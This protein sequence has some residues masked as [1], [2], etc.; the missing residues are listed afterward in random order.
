M[1]RHHLDTASG[2][3]LVGG[4]M[5]E[6]SDL[7]TGVVAGAAGPLV[8]AVL[9]GERAAERVLLVGARAATLLDRVPDRLA[10][11]VLVRGLP[12]ARELAGTSRL[13]SGLRVFTGSVE[14]LEP[15][16]HY[17]VLVCLDGPDGV[18][19]P[20]SDGITPAALL[21]LLGSWLAPGGLL[22]AAVQNEL[23]L[24]RLLR[25]DPSA[26][27]QDDA[28]HA[29]SPGT[30]TRLPYEREVVGLL[31]AAGLS[32]EASWSGFP[33]AD[34]L[35]LLV[36]PTRVGSAG[37]VVA[38]LAARLQAGYF[39]DRPA[40]ADPHDLALRTFEGG[41][42]PAL[43]SAWVV[44]ARAGRPGARAADLPPLLA[45]GEPGTQPWRA[46]TTLVEDPAGWQL[47]LA[48]EAGQPVVHERHVLRDLT[49]RPDPPAEGTT[50][51]EALRVA[52]RSGS[53]P[54][55]RE[56]VRRYAAWLTSQPVGEAGDQRF[57][58]TPAQVVLADDGPHALDR[59]WHW[60]GPMDPEVA[61]LRGLRDFARAL[62]RS[63]SDQPWRPDISPD[64]LAQT[65]AAMA[66][67]PWTPALLDRIAAA[68]A[69]VETV[70]TGG[71]ALAEARAHR[72]NL[73]SGQSQAGAV[74]GPSRGYR[75]AVASEGRLAVAL[76][77]RTGQVEWL[78][79][80]LRSRD[81]KVSELERTVSHLRGSLSFRIGRVLTSPMRSVTGY[82]RRFVMSLVPPEYLRQ[83]RRLAERLARPE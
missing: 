57:F 6:W 1:R 82:L 18:V 39:R 70:L 4:E 61:V 62:V 78:E 22:V 25:L 37:G 54:Q 30:S 68:E 77:E 17:D 42:T 43:A 56:L 24:D 31:E 9:R 48:P 34:R 58:L 41:L 16:D 29:A 50:L 65:L 44:L 74:Q 60:T 67:L 19:S 14:R 11:D 73:E 69:E 13:R 2:A 79:A 15:E 76:E 33:A 64:D 51:D 49:V 66:G 63:G 8:D 21:N 26:V 46:V 45:A 35:D 38:A 32:L 27:R 40:L 23:G 59:S 20:D 47:A 81:T 80:S 75:E 7:A 36:D 52:C 71:D 72:A 12:D 83:A 5:L 10:I 28:W 55:V 3:R 53:L